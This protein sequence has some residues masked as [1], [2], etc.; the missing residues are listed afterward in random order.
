MGIA[1][2]EHK[3][4]AQAGEHRGRRAEQSESQQASVA[5]MGRAKENT[6]R[7]AGGCG[8]L[9]WLGRLTCGRRL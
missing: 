5:E 3:C 4:T 2:P 7:A 8:K 6:R 1:E 9:G